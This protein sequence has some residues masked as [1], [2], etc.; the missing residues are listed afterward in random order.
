MNNFESKKKYEESLMNL[1]EDSLEDFFQSILSPVIY[2]PIAS[3]IQDDKFSMVFSF[4]KILKNIFKFDFDISSVLGKVK[5]SYSF[6]D[7]SGE[8]MESEERKYSSQNDLID[9]YNILAKSIERDFKKYLMNKKYMDYVV[10]SL[11]ELEKVNTGEDERDELPSRSLSELKQRADEVKSG[12]ATIDKKDDI[13]EEERVIDRNKFKKI[14]INSYKRNKSGKAVKIVNKILD[15]PDNSD[16]I[17][18]IPFKNKDQTSYAVYYIYD[19]LL[20]I[21]K[22][23]KDQVSSTVKDIADS[24]SAVQWIKNKSKTTKLVRQVLKFV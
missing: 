3:K 17:N 21:D 19:R 8:V 11:D 22:S 18:S 1:L 6:F 15:N 24:F 14:L 20:D 2:N 16:L 12:K 9:E 5:V 10:T 13:E 7:D 23:D 4:E